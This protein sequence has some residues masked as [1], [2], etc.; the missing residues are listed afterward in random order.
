MSWSQDLSALSRPIN[1]PR[2]LHIYSQLRHQETV[3]LIY[4]GDETE[5]RK[6][7]FCVSWQS[8]RLQIRILKPVWNVVESATRESYIVP[9]KILTNSQTFYVFFSCYKLVS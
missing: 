6:K 1:N 9:S 5:G 2:I 7:R 8:M 4:W 3:K